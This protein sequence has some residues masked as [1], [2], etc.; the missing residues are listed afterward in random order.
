MLFTVCL[1][2][3]MNR[4]N[5][6]VNILAMVQPVEARGNNGTHP[7]VGKFMCERGVLFLL[8]IAHS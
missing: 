1:I 6:S 8:K 7:E 3:Y 5:V 2:A 4:V